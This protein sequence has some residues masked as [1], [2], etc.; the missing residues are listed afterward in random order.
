MKKEKIVFLEEF[1]RDPVRE[2]ERQY[3]R[4]RR[5]LSKKEAFMRIEKALIDIEEHFS[6]G[7][8]VAAAR[9]EIASLRAYCRACAFLDQR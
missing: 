9:E 1:L 7:G 8:S 2:Y 6:L 4:S 5:T 3:G